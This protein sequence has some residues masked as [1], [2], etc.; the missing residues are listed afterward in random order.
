MAGF[1]AK[2][3]KI[4]VSFGRGWLHVHKIPVS[5][6]EPPQ[7]RFQTFRDI[8]LRNFY[9]CPND[10]RI[11]Y[12]AKEQTLW[13]RISY[14]IDRHRHAKIEHCYVVRK[15]CED[16]TIVIFFAKGS[17][18]CQ[19]FRSKGANPFK[20]QKCCYRSYLQC[21]TQWDTSDQDIFLNLYNQCAIRP[22]RIWCNANVN[23]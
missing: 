1:L 10:F 20:K 16:I 15:L 6:T 13:Y 12:S 5:T 23:R 8:S 19:P 3:Q 18:K 7:S 17:S 9:E 14:V 21:Q 2:D 4:H 11:K 22:R